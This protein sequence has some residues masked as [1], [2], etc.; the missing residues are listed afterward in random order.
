M[1]GIKAQRVLGPKRLRPGQNSLRPAP[2][3]PQAIATAGRDPQAKRVNAD[4]NGDFDRGQAGPNGIKRRANSRR[5]GR[6]P[7]P[8]D[9]RRASCDGARRPIRHLVPQ[10]RDQQVRRH[11]AG[12]AGQA[13]RLRQT[14]APWNRAEPRNAAP[15]DGPSATI[16]ELQ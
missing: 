13:G 16:N 9:S 15:Q 8:T 1:T 2:A 6:S 4:L 5:A 7:R 14:A 3:L 10:G 11:W 12:V